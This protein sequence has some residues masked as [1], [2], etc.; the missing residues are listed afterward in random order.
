MG[1]RIETGY[2][3]DGRGVS[4]RDPVGPPERIWTNA[5]SIHRNQEA[6]YLVVK[7]PERET[8]NSTTNVEMK[9][10]WIYTSTSL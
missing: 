8:G 1:E 5:G 6:L 2:W 9:Q 3:L 10:T 4:V 7:L